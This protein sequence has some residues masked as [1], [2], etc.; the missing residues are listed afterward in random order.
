ME[1]HLY[2]FHS[3]IQQLFIYLLVLLNRFMVS[4]FEII[5]PTLPHYVTFIIIIV[6][7]FSVTH[8]AADHYQLMD[9]IYRFLGLHSL[10]YVLGYFMFFEI[11]SFQHLNILCYLFLCLLF[12]HWPFFVSGSGL[13]SESV[14]QLNRLINI[15]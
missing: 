3:C 8:F 9:D 10:G 1:I 4:S 12:R 15:I 7:I 14:R 5:W 6:I 2:F 13:Q 11:L